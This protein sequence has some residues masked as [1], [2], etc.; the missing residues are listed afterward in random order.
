[1][2]K[3]LILGLSFLNM[4]LLLCS[5]HAE[6]MTGAMAY[7][8]SGDVTLRGYVYRPEGSGPFP[9]VV[10]L[11]TGN[12]PI[13]ESAPPV[14]ELGKFYTDKGFVLF[15]PMH[16]SAEELKV[17]VKGVQ[18]KGNNHKKGKITL[19]EYTVMT[20]DIA[21]A[22]TWLKSQSFVNENRVAV[23]GQGSGAVGALLLSQQDVEVSGYIIFSPAAQTWSVKPELRDAMTYAIRESKVP[24]FLIQ[25]QNDYSLEPSQALAKELAL[26][27][28]L[29]TSKVY[30]PFGTT[31]E[32]AAQF[33]AAG[34]SM[35][36]TDVI[37]FLGKVFNL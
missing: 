4:A 9:A 24:I 23:A 33:A 17:E 2:K 18:A 32:R 3:L 11:R 19:P 16:R 36:G 31:H 34:S 29:N 25:P 5:A 21:A 22:V 6:K 30:P 20:K 12:K 1:M 10:Y 26:K 8:R 7:F 27:G 14:P 35:W 15:V 37:A 28:K 13:T